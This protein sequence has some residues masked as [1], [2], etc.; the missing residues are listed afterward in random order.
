MTAASDFPSLRSIFSFGLLEDEAASA[1]IMSKD[2]EEIHA[3]RKRAMMIQALLGKKR[4]VAASS[5]RVQQMLL[6]RRSSVSTPPGTS[7]TLSIASSEQPIE[8]SGTTPRFTASSV[9]EQ[10]QQ[11]QMKRNLLLRMP[12]GTLTT[13]LERLSNKE[14][15]SLLRN[16]VD[17]G[18][19]SS[20]AIGSDLQEDRIKSAALFSNQASGNG[21]TSNYAR[22]DDVLAPNRGRGHQDENDLMFPDGPLVGLERET[23]STSSK[24]KTVVRDYTQLR[25]P[26]NSGMNGNLGDE[27]VGILNLLANRDLEYNSQDFHKKVQETRQ[28]ISFA[29]EQWVLDHHQRQDGTANGGGE[30][31][32]LASTSAGKGASS[33]SGA[34]SQVLMLLNKGRGKPAAYSEGEG[35]PEETLPSTDNTGAGSRTKTSAPTRNVNAPSAAPNNQQRHQAAELMT[36]VDLLTLPWNTTPLIHEMRQRQTE[37]ERAKILKE[38]S[39]GALR[40]MGN[41]GYPKNAPHRLNPAYWLPVLAKFGTNAVGL[42]GLTLGFGMSQMGRGLVGT[43]IHENPAMEAG[44]LT[45]LRLNGLTCTVTFPKNQSYANLTDC[46]FMIANH[47]SYL[48]GIV[49]ATE[50]NYPKIM[51]MNAVKNA[52]MIGEFMKDMEVIW[53]DRADP[54]SRKNALKAIKRHGKTWKRGDRP[55]FVFPEGYTTSGRTILPF[56]PGVFTAGMPIRPCVILYTGEADLGQPEWIRSKATDGHIVLREYA[57]SEWF[58]QLMRG[59]V[60]SVIVKVCRVYYPNDQEKND[61]ALYA[62]NMHKYMK[63]EYDRLKLLHDQRTRKIDLK[64]INATGP[65]Y[66]PDNLLLGMESKNDAIPPGGDLDRWPV[67]LSAETGKGE[68]VVG[69]SWRGHMPYSATQLDNMRNWY[70]AKNKEMIL[71]GQA[72]RQAELQEQRDAMRRGSGASTTAQLEQSVQLDERAKT[73]RVHTMENQLEVEV[74]QQDERR[75]TST[76][77]KQRRD[78]QAESAQPLSGRYGAAPNQNSRTTPRLA[79]AATGNMAY[80]D[81][82]D[83]ENERRAGFDFDFD[84]VSRRSSEAAAQSMQRQVEHGREHRLTLAQFLEQ[85]DEDTNTILE[86]LSDEQDEDERAIEKHLLAIGQEVLNKKSRARAEGEQAPP[87]AEMNQ[88]YD[89]EQTQHDPHERG[90]EDS[91]FIPR[92][93]GGGAGGRQVSTTSAARDNIIGDENSGQE[94]KEGLDVKSNGGTTRCST[95]LLV[96]ENGKMLA[97][98]PKLLPNEPES[99]FPNVSSTASSMDLQA[100]ALRTPTSMEDHD[101]EFL[102]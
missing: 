62:E 59:M 102:V 63:Y 67:R 42:A 57:D 49:V 71:R 48:D 46:P 10:A 45:F 98:P 33:R 72:L 80:D 26:R 84:P 40:D 17:N 66:S 79:S 15:Q 58:D 91:L 31:Q 24:S 69:K 73:Q 93:D 50:L 74:Q 60:H 39:S 78:S 86:S 53:V 89:A 100:S 82:V 75:N 96:D 22:G 43:R 94:N 29:Q 37:E 36:S 52:P 12:S 5:A 38:F 14:L 90:D 87:P 65:G 8:G 30:Q 88:E 34:N 56:K 64:K 68:V 77:S 3:G 9:G 44:L 32:K 99:S 97:P 19:S 1:N 76:T 27:S 6:P 7:D 13:L 54:N 18:A 4:N 92:I 2:D 35:N 95:S 83:D 41:Y 81:V 101:E 61:P 23:S 20:A 47:Q 25:K 55:L 11:Y 28:R 51:S 16:G 70:L 85:A 21:E